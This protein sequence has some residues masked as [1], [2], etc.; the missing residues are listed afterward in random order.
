MNVK[1]DAPTGIWGTTGVWGTGEN[2]GEGPTYVPSVF[3]KLSCR[4][5]IV[6][7]VLSAAVV[8][9]AFQYDF[10][11]WL[12]LPH[13][14]FLVYYL[15][16]AIPYFIHYKHRKNRKEKRLIWYVFILIILIVPLRLPI[17]ENRIEAY[18][19]FAIALQNH[20]IKYSDCSRGSTPPL[21]NQRVMEFHFLNIPSGL[22]WTN[23]RV[24]KFKYS[25]DR[26]FLSHQHLDD[27]HKFSGGVNEELILVERPD[28]TQ[29]LETYKFLNN[30]WI[31]QSD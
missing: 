15:T 7:V 30:E 27:V 11:T 19:N 5:L 31:S 8:P 4:A 14:V 13:F 18:K 1:Q 28:A 20:C 6:L 26:F 16:T 12:L 24:M 29:K 22:P 21:K 2:V 25:R 3:L 23:G 17:H 9:S 10:G